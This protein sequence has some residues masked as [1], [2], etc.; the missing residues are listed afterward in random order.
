MTSINTVH[1]LGSAE[2]AYILC[3]F[4]D[5]WPGDTPEN[6]TRAEV[7]ALVRTSI[8]AWGVS[9][10]RSEGSWD[11]DLTEDEAL[12]VA[13]WAVAQIRRLYPHLD[14]PALTEYENQYAKES[15][16]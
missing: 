15:D 12:F 13:T 1:H 4:G 8:R 5:A 11:E 9:A 7:D 14:D 10:Y 6:L 16:T 2:I 3:R